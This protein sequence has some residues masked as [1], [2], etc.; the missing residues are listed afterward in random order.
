MVIGADGQVSRMLNT[1]EKYCKCVNLHWQYFSPECKI[2]S[3]F[4]NI[5]SLS[6]W[7][8]LPLGDGSACLVFRCHSLYL[9][10]LCRKLARHHVLTV[11][12]VAVAFCATCREFD[13]HAEQ[14]FLCAMD[15]SFGYGCVYLWY[16]KKS[17]DWNKFYFIKN[18]VKYKH[19]FTYINIYFI[20]FS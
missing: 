19:I 16:S 17:K 12:F 3:R 8:W 18:K 4:F 10:Y 20:W 7:L 11:G 9:W 13:F 14:L 2:I 6:S 15:I 1:C 5:V